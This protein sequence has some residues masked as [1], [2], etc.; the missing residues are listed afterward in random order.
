M[1]IMA[2]AMASG[3]NK[4]TSSFLEQKY[5]V[6]VH[7]VSGSIDA[8]GKKYDLQ[9]TADRFQVDQFAEDIE[10]TGADYVIFTAWHGGMLPLYPSTVMESYR[11]GASAKRDLIGEI[12]DALNKRNISVWLYTHPYLGYHFSNAARIAT[13]YGVGNNPDDPNLPNPETFDYTKWNNFV[14]AV[15]AELMERYGNRIQGLFLDEG[16]PSAAMADYIDYPRLRKTIKSVN[17][18]VIMMQN[19]Y[20]TNYSCDIGMKE[21]GPG[22]GEFKSNNG[23]TTWPCYE[24]PVGVTISTDWMAKTPSGSS[25]VRYTVENMFR[26]TVLQAGCNIDGGGTCWAAGPYV[27]GGWEDNVL[28]TLQEVGKMYTAAGE[29][30]AGTLPSTSYPTVSGNSLSTLKNGIVATRSSDDQFEYIHVLNPPKTGKSLTLP[31]PE[32]G[33]VFADAVLL[34]NGHTVSMRKTNT[35]LILTLSAQDTWDSVDT[36]IR[37]KKTGQ[38][39]PSWTKTYIR[40]TDTAI[41]YSSNWEYSRWERNCGDYEGDMHQTNEKGA[42]MSYTFSGTG[43]AYLAPTSWEQGTVAV[44]LDGVLQK[45]VNAQCDI[46]NYT[47]QQILFEAKGLSSGKHTL[48]L[49]NTDGRRLCVDGLIVFTGASANASSTSS[50]ASNSVSRV[51]GNLTGQSSKESAA[52]ISTS[53]TS[54]NTL[55]NASESTDSLESATKDT[56]KSIGEGNKGNISEVNSTGVADQNKLSVFWIMAGILLCVAG[57][58]I[59]VLVLHLKKGI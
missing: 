42:W 17:T 2:S 4:S 48:K 50:K 34:S 35:S 36:I 29:S 19:F 58:G 49:V 11:P 32:D 16:T 8:N 12:V 45:E 30:L 7:Y 43:I 57:I 21:Y 51:T 39:A 6:F 54:N 25:P 13:G 59:F 52:T 40:D 22:W 26:Y 41:T 10:S 3:V 47:P 20:G 23:A 46:N 31:L 33:K 15:Y 18:N 5:G 14:N 53:D 1:K 55:I 44:Y 56:S 38:T 37:L 27:G 28:E 24:M 9:T